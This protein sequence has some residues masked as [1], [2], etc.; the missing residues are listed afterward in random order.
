MA[1]RDNK[2]LGYGSHFSCTA[3]EG[4]A[5]CVPYAGLK[6]RVVA[7]ET[8]SVELDHE[9]VSKFESPS[10]FDES[11]IIELSKAG[12]YRVNGTV[13]LNTNNCVFEIEVKGLSFTIDLEETLGA[14]PK[15]GERV[16]FTVHRLSLWDEGK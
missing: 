16:S 13:I 4:Y 12:D 9:S 10:I 11:G 2:S 1:V 7:G 5:I 15:I 14:I 6:D 3:V 8:L